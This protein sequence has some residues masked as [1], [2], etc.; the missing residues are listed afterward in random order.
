MRSR[1]ARP[2]LP[3]IR[4]DDLRAGIFQL[5]RQTQILIDANQVQVV[6]LAARRLACLYDLLVRAGMPRIRGAM[7]VSDRYLE[8]REK[9]L[10]VTGV[11]ILDDSVVL[12]TTLHRL[13]SDASACYPTARI[14]C[15][16][17]VV[18]RDQRAEYLLEPLNFDSLYE[19]GSDDVRT[20]A[21]DLVQALSQEQI[22]FF[23]DYLATKPRAVPQAAWIE[24][25]RSPGWHVAD[26]TAPLLGHEQQ[27]AL[28]QVPS[29]ATRRTILSRLIPP[30]AAISDT[31]KIR[32]YLRTEGAT[33]RVVFV[34]LAIL[35]P[36]TPQALDAC[37]EAM[38][39][40]PARVLLK[41]WNT[42]APEA[43]QRV[44]QLYAS[45]CVLKEAA[46]DLPVIFSERE[47]ASLFADLLDP[48]R[49]HVYFGEHA[50]TIAELL[51]TAVTSY[52][53]TQADPDRQPTQYR[54]DVP[55]SSG[56]LDDGGIQNILFETRELIAD[57]GLPARPDVGMLTKVG[58]IFAHAF[59]SIF[60]YVN[61][62]FELPQRDEIRRLGSIEAYERWL[63][64]G[65]TRL[66]NQGLTLREMTEA[67]VPECLLGDSWQRSLVSLGIDMGNDLGIVV[68][69]T[70]YDARRDVVY[71]C[72]RLGET[73]HLASRPL[74]TVVQ[75]EEP[76][77][78]ELTKA[79]NDGYA[80]RPEVVP[81]PDSGGG[82]TSKSPQTLDG[83]LR[84]VSQVIQGRL[85]GRYLGAVTAVHESSFEAHLHSA[86]DE[87]EMFADMN[88]EQVATS[89]RDLVKRGA[90]FTWCTFAR[91]AEGQ[92][93][94][95][96]SRVRFMP[97]PPPFDPHQ[98]A[99]SADHE[100]VI[101]MFGRGAE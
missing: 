96:T 19:R 75:E 35:A 88:I 97:A 28:A 7:V 54:L 41:V 47:I 9:D 4:D 77:Y 64:T 62:A 65:S 12:G 42:W 89:Q 57:I 27:Q 63:E 82:G 72:Y 61:D 98:L 17:V 79:V 101:T 48:T 46:D 21:A 6:I 15:R 2:A 44:I 81:I 34:P 50:E 58:L 53:E 33:V 14:Y 36:C 16:T 92:A 76:V 30:V 37:L 38:Q 45:L 51:D 20:F 66:I 43:R 60:G 69:V 24:Y 84:T 11:M 56:L 31:F 94:S 90:E 23:T 83:L 55:T 3:A 71:R 74:V 78:D 86:D 68:P 87:L 26:V 100:T 1:R 85:T 25:L 10:Q 67:L 8:L 93:K 99:A 22:P 80:T 40:E 18:D 49:L 13:F 73:A 95:S 32:S 59:S 5:F 70:R 39:A 29:D 52:G 91:E